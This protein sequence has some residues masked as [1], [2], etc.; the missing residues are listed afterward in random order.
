[1]LGLLIRLWTLSAY[2][3]FGIKAVLAALS[4]VLASR[5]SIGTFRVCAAARAP[6][7]MVDV[8]DLI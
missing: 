2:N 8:L 6:E 5:C 3:G 1:M 4:C 7:D